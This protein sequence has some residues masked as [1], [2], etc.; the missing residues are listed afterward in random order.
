MLHLATSTYSQTKAVTKAWLVTCYGHSRHPRAKSG[1][2]VEGSGSEREAEEA[3][4]ECAVCYSSDANLLNALSYI[5]HA[6]GSSPSS[7]V[8]VRCPAERMAMNMFGKNRNNQKSLSGEIH[9]SD[10][11]HYAF[12]SVPTELEKD[13]TS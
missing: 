6:T 2:C 3:A 4:P 10:D 1:F 13:P 7:W 5:D 8:T 9:N 12:G 11:R